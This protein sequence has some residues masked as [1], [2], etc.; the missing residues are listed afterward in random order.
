MQ[1]VR[2]AQIDKWTVSTFCPYPGCAIYR[3]P[4]KFGIEITNFDYSRWWNYADGGYNHVIYGQNQ[5]HMWARY[6]EFYEYLK[7]ES[8]KK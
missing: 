5:A 2:D 1:F 6:L 3:S 7:G 4:G 8:W